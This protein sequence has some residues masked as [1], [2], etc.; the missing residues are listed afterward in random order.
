[1]DEAYQTAFKLLLEIID[2][3]KICVG[4]L[5][6]VKSQLIELRAVLFNSPVCL[7]NL[8]DLEDLVP[9]AKPKALVL[10]PFTYTQCKK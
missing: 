5:A 6:A 8:E 9:K 3:I 2:S 4:T 1:M 7:V 10:Q